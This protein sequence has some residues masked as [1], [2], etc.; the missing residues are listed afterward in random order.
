MIHESV[1]GQRTA[2]SLDG[3]WEFRH[4]DGLWRTANV[5]N[6]WQ[7]EFADLRHASGREL[8][9]PHLLRSGPRAGT[10]M[11]LRFGAV[12]YFA[13]V[14]VNGHEVG[15]H[16]GGWLPFECRLDPA[17]LRGENLLDVSCLLP[18]GDPATSPEAP[19]AEIPH[20]KQS[21]YGPQGGIWQ[22]V[23]LE[24]RHPCHLARAAIHRDPSGR[25]AYGFHFPPVPSAPLQG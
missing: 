3:P 7:A 2:V 9:P 4:Q 16:E 20:G 19:F 23:T 13:E 8:L 21:W 24:L 6:P 12:S 25:I 17:L 22:S 18:V 11:C 15:R 1:Y 5:P 14:R 10:E